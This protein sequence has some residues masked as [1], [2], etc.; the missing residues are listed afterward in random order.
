MN[1]QTITTL[2]VLAVAVVAF[3]SDRVPPAVVAVGV[4]LALYITG[5]LTFE[6]T[7]AGFGDPVVVYIA[8]LFVVSEALDATGVTAWAGQ[9]LSCRVGNNS[10][11]V[12]TALM[13]MV[14]ALTALISINGAVAALIPVAVVL[15]TRTA[16]PPARLLLPLAF[17]A[18]AGSMLTLLGTPVNLLVTELAVDAGARPFGFFEFGV[19]GVP[20]LAGTVVIVLILGPKVLPD[21]APPNAPRDLSRHA[22]TLAAHYA[23][24]PSHTAMSYDAGVTE[25]VI[26]PRSPFEGDVVFPGM[27]TE[28]GELIVVA[29]KRAGV[30]LDHA[31][32]QAGDF[33]LLR[34]AWDVLDRHAA[35]PGV[36]AVDEPTV[37]RRQTIHLGARSYTSIAVV[38]LMCALLAFDVAPAAIIAL[39]AAAAMVA[40]RVLSLSQAQQSID[41]PTLV[42]V[43]G[44]IPLSTAIQ[45]SGAADLTSDAL[46]RAVGGGS[47]LLLQLGIVVVVLVLGQFISNL[48]TVLVVAPIALSTADA[49]GLSPLPFLMGIAVA[50]AAAFITPVATPANLMIMDPGALRFGDYWKLGLPLLLLFG[51]VATFLVPVIWRF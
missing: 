25:I 35:H 23:I 20:L 48:A 21:R 43:A 41:L 40:L 8:A 31:E 32:L 7:I 36:V 27:R 44:M 37:L 38:V 30:A 11:A 1:E 10:R 4:A 49:A 26:A 13:L 50:G 46:L 22:E 6:Q 47:P 2:V 39:T 45:T 17:A 14:A 3:V 19:V 5:T 16:Q 15:A 24:E 33:L 51:A 28:S 29:V 34:G 42:V 18:H 12:V 9:Q